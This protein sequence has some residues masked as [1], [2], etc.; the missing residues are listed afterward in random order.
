MREDPESASV[1]ICESWVASSFPVVSS[2]VTETF[3]TLDI[4]LKL[5]ILDELSSAS[6]P[7]FSKIPEPESVSECPPMLTVLPVYV[8]FFP[9][10]T[11]MLE[12]ACEVRSDLTVM[13]LSAF[14]VPPLKATVPPSRDGFLSLIHI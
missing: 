3:L 6:E 13:S 9:A 2:P 7:V 10:A 8:T 11:E 1:S 5:R 4:P 12:S 14:S